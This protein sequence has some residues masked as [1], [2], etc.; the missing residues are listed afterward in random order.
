MKNAFLNENLEEEVFMDH[1]LGF[2]E[3]KGR[4]S[5]CKLENPSM[6]SSSHL[7]LGSSALGKY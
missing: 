7:K 4:Q 2:E 6:D 1:S 5:V 3:K